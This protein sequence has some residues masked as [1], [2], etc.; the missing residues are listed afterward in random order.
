MLK[1]YGW[2]RALGLAGIVVCLSGCGYLQ[3][4]APVSYL[5]GADRERISQL[6][7]GEAAG[8]EAAAGPDRSVG[9]D[10]TEQT[11]ESHSAATGTEVTQGQELVVYV[12]G[13]VNAPGVYRFEEGA[14]VYEAIEAAQGFSPD[15]AEAALNLADLMKD[16]Q[17]I[18]V[19]KTGEEEMQ[20]F[21][22][23]MAPDE[24]SEAGRVSINRASR[25]EL[26]QLPGIG[27]ARA[28][29][30]LAY[31]SEHG[32]FSDIEEI[33]QVPGIKE[34]AFSKLKERITVD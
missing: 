21:G 16:G 8:S 28:D 19:P 32:G 14:R 10:V 13:C 26:M 1:K 30:I 17:R 3:E 24:T 33:M 22:Q 31:R 18:Y 9:P 34:A 6:S 29:A 2:K 15:A 5:A 4:E 25:E 12:C 7:S 20:P 23:D 11:G 27:G